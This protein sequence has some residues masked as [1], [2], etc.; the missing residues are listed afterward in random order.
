LESLPE[1][2]PLAHAPPP[3]QPTPT[4]QHSPGSPHD[5]AAQAQRKADHSAQTNSVP[6]DS[7]LAEHDCDPDL[8]VQPPE[9]L[10]LHEP[11]VDLD[12]EESEIDDD[13]FSDLAEAL[14]S[15]PDLEETDTLSWD[16]LEDL[17][18]FDEL[19][20]R[21]HPDQLPTEDTLTRAM[22]ARQVAVEILLECEWPS[23]AIDLL[24]QVFIEDGWGAARVAIERELKKGLVPDELAL[25]RVVRGYWSENERFWTTFQR[26]KT[27]APFMQADAAYRHMS[28]AE[29]LR[30]VRCFPAIP[31]AEEVT[32]LIE[33]T[34]DWWYNDASLRRSFKI[35]LKFLKYRTGSMRGALPGHCLFDFLE[36]PECGP[37]TD[38]MEL[39]HSMTPGRRYL[40]ELG[41]QLPLDGEEP[42]RNIIRI[43]QE[44]K[45]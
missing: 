27:N 18:E 21:E 11:E 33:E 28:W 16:D 14:A 4:P 29:A 42:P 32:G 34:Y 5:R 2:K 8:D 19:A 9:E 17:D 23:S 31:A 6:G 35:F 12:L 7:E 25:A 3:R 38:S 40:W 22:R 10:S 26:I 41:I 36:W 43:S 45:E 30:I 44:Q 24:Q 20:Q 1:A 15:I 39:L 13:G 37:E